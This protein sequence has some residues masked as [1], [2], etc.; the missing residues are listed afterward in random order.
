MSDPS[1]HEDPIPL[2]ANSIYNIS[3]GGSVTQTLFFDYY[4]PNAI[5]DKLS[6]DQKNHQME[7]STLWKNLQYYLD[8]EI[9]HVNGQITKQKI[10]H[11]N[12]DHHGL[13]NLPYIYWIIRWDGSSFQLGKNIIES[14][15]DK[16]TAKYD[17]EI[18]WVFPEET[19]I[20]VVQTNLHHEIMDSILSLWG[21]KG[22]IV[23]GKEIISFELFNKTTG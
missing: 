6:H 5:Y 15:A 12:Y 3:L 14:I 23:G 16:E 2:H 22:E 9:I 17:F 10:V 18:V 1:K 11:V 21:R 20:S 8:R 4:D 19:R 13:R 7:I